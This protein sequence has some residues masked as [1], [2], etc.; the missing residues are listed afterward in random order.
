M[1]KVGTTALISWGPGNPGLTENPRTVLRMMAGLGD[2]TNFNMEHVLHGWW[3]TSSS[4]S[5]GSG[6][7]LDQMA[8]T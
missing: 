3:H 8:G 5:T 4:K 1:I 7:V 6:G 2:A